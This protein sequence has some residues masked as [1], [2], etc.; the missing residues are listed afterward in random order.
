M[1]VPAFRL[2]PQLLDKSLDELHE[3]IENAAKDSRAPAGSEARKIGD[4]YASFMDEAA[5]E[6]AGLG[7][8]KTELSG[9]DALKSKSELPALFAHLNRIG[10]STP[11]GIGVGPDIRDTTHNAAGVDQDGLGMPDRDYYIKDDDARM[12]DTRGRYQKAIEK[13]MALAGQPDA[14][15]QAKAI[16]ALETRMAKAQW[17]R[18][19]LR[20]PGQDL[21]QG[22]PE[23]LGCEHARL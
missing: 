9:I 17:T 15:A 8:L 4:L 7:S 19:A 1:I 2:P 18:T 3:V 13:L 20:E 12:V 10:V 5:V 23:E 6:A 11:Y 14:A 21:Q 16:L 22:V